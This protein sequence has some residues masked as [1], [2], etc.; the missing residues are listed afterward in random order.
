[1]L[2]AHPELFAFF[3]KSNQARGIQPRTLANAVVAYASNIENLGVLTGFHGCPVD[4]MA[5]THCGLQ[6]V[7]DQYP[8]VHSNLM[9]AIG[10]VCVDW[11][12]E[13]PP[14]REI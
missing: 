2:G 12:V 1:M 14:L 5:H 11:G 3:N 8:I 9:G 13:V 10:K 7:P 6:V 4:I